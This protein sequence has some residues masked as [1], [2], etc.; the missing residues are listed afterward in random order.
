MRNKIPI[1]S[2]ALVLGAI[3]IG[4]LLAPGVQPANEVAAEAAEKLIEDG[5]VD[6]GLA[7]M[8]GL[9]NNGNTDAMVF[10]GGA[11]LFGMHGLAEEKELAYKWHLKAAKAGDSLGQ[12][13]T[14]KQL[15]SGTGVSRD[16]TEAVAWWRKSAEAG[17]PP[18]MLDLGAAYAMGL[19][20]LEKNMTEAFSWISRAAEM[21]DANAQ[22]ELG[23]YYSLGRGVSADKTQAEYWMR[24]AAEQ[25]N[26][27]GMQLLALRKL[28]AKDYQEAFEWLTKS[29]DAGDRE[30]EYWLGTLYEG[31]R[32]VERNMDKALALYQSAADKGF[33]RAQN[34]LA[35]LQPGRPP[36]LRKRNWFSE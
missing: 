25:G 29:A 12:Y 32:G 4:L 3:A 17:F 34:R 18:G 13:M 33:E 20:G 6:E 7:Q 10:L 22:A 23:I 35:E 26:E 36:T 15:A 30:S 21:G 5:R 14:G 31:G 11:Y 8:K 2:G 9:A 1:I 28:A 24:K 19:G 27:K 16:Q